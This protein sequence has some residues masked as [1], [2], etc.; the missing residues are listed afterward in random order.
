MTESISLEQQQ[1]LFLLLST[2]LTQL[3]ADWTWSSEEEGSLSLS[4]SRI[5]T[6]RA[7]RDKKILSSRDANP[8]M[9]NHKHKPSFTR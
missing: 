5:P 8:G 4:L 7:L 1:K 9:H 6:K 2:D 3:L